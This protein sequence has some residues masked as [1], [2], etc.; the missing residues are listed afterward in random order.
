MS[1]NLQMQLDK[2]FANWSPETECIVVGSSPSLKWY[3]FGDYIDQFNTVVR[4]NRCFHPDMSKYTGKKHDIWATTSNKRNDYNYTPP[5]DNVKEVWP[6]LPVTGRQLHDNGTLDNYKGEVV[7]MRNSSKRCIYGSTTLNNFASTGIGTGLI[8]LN[9]AVERYKK[10]TVIGHTF[11]L[12]SSDGK[13]MD[14]HSNQEDAEHTINREGHYNG[15]EYGL[16]SLK[17]VQDWI[18]QGR[19][20]L[21]NPYEF[22]NLRGVKSTGDEK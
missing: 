19:V 10:I 4:V 14:F 3:D 13:A 12:E 18:T 2:H 21:L 7:N 15:N 22:D 20:V 1:T 5:L 9:Y 8:A 6:R 11:Y 16:I 17:Y